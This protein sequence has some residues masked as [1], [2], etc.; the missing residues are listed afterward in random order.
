[1][2]RDA[3]AGPALMLGHLFDQVRLVHVCM[4]VWC[5]CVCVCVREREREGLCVLVTKY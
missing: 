5:M 3:I 2:K 1:V 4:Y